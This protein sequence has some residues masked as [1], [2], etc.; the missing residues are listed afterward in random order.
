MIPLHRL[1]NQEFVLNA[2]LIETIEATPDTLITLTDG[3]KL[4]VLDTIADIVER[5]VG[6]RQ[7]C[8]STIRVVREEKKE[9][10]PEE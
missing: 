8:N 1:H 10:L 9:Q 3:K 7:L 6:Y 5:V 2:D 4:L